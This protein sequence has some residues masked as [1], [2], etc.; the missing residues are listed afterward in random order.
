[1]VHSCRRAAC[2]ANEPV[3][4]RQRPAWEIA[5][6]PSLPTLSA[7]DAFYG[8]MADMGLRYGE[9]F[10]PI[11]ELSAGAGK[12]CWSRLRLG[13]AIS[14]ACR[15]S[16]RC[17]PCSFDGA[18]QIS[19]LV[20]RRLKAAPPGCGFRFALHAF[21]FLARPGASSR[22]RAGVKQANDEFVEGGIELV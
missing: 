7:L 11:R 19:P 5:Q 1:M 17:I 12:S 14:A 16:I 10:R 22:V 8:H 13:T 6:S 9:E 21:C 18:L 4:L 20:P 15:P 2:A 3:F